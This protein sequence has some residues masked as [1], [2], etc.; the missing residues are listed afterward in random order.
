V[1]ASSSDIADFMKRVKKDVLRQNPVKIYI[2]HIEKNYPYKFAHGR[3]FPFFAKFGQKG[4]RLRI[5]HIPFQ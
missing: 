4:I 5:V 3:S 2:R 1:N